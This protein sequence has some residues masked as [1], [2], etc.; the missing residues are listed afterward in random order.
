MLSRLKR[1]Y[2]VEVTTR[3]PAIPYKETIT[4]T[5]EASHR[6]KKQTG[7]HGE[8]AEVHLRVEP[9][10]R[11]AG[12]E[13]V[14]EVT[15]GA[16]PRQFIPAVE[17]GVRGVLDRGVLS[18]SPVVDVRAAV[19]FGKD[20]PVDSSEAAFKKAAARAF[21]QAFNE[22]KPV[23][24]EPIV[25]MDVTIPSEFMGE[26]TS[27]LTSHRGR[28]LGMDSLGAMQIVKTEIPLAE[29]TSY[30]TELKSMTQ[31]QGS[32]TME[33]SRLDVVPSHLQQQIV[34][35]AKKEAEEED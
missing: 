11:G 35:A 17:K 22:A 18:G 25:K 31:G 23:L 24:L 33:F 21:R 27:H 3:P 19:F 34:A 26:I 2:D 1:R 20:H 32:F 5:A 4:R 13:F 6:H 15:G 7:G 29:V 28:I 9:L 14:D 12:F 10:E 16:I 30:S 8:F